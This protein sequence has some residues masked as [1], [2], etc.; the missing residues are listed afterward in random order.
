M[1]LI[2]QT[3]LA[4]VCAVVGQLAVFA[5]ALLIWPRQP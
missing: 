4:C 2:V 1:M 5:L 3:V